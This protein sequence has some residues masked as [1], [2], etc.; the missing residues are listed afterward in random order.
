[1]RKK[2]VERKLERKLKRELQP[3][4]D[5]WKWKISVDKYEVILFEHEKII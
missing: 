2:K 4:W 3:P 1:M 5:S